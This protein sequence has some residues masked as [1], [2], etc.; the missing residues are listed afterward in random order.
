MRPSRTKLHAPSTSLRWLQGKPSRTGYWVSSISFT[1]RPILSPAEKLDRSKA[2]ISL[3][4]RRQVN[5]FDKL[6][7]HPIAFADRQVLVAID[8]AHP[9]R[10]RQSPH[11]L[12]IVLGVLGVGV[13]LRFRHQVKA[14]LLRHADYVVLP[15]V[16]VGALGVL[17]QFRVAAMFLD[18][19][20]AA[21][22][23]RLVHR[24]EDLRS[25][26]AH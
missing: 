6:Q 14:G 9:Q 23:E 13:D 17:W 7:R 26:P 8:I 5:R 15:Y 11:T 10:W 21:R 19:E 22:L 2:R 18:A 3:P 25:E 4:L 20:N 16:A 1:T 24:L 12:G